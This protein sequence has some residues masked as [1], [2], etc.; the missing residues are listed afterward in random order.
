VRIAGKG[1]REII[2]P[3]VSKKITQLRHIRMPMT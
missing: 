1:A 2:A 3:D